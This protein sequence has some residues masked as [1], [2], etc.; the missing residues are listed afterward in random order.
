[1][2]FYEGNENNEKATIAEGMK[3]KR[4]I[5]LFEVNVPV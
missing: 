5:N 1:M 4:K 2:V 3:E